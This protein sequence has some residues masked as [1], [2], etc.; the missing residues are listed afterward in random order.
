MEEE[1]EMERALSCKCMIW[2]CCLLTS[3]WRSEATLAL[4]KEER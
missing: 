3:S 2:A 4:D 1:A